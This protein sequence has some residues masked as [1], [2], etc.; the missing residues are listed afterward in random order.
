M[1]EALSTGRPVE[2]V[3]KERSELYDRWLA[4]QAR[5]AEESAKRAR[6]DATS[7]AR[8]RKRSQGD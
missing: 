5:D 7:T 6:T 2:D 8:G 3:R 4:E 1:T